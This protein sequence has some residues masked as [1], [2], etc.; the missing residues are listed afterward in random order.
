MFLTPTHFWLRCPLAIDNDRSP[1]LIEMETHTFA[2]LS[3]TVSF[4][5]PGSDCDYNWQSPLGCK[6]DTVINKAPST[7]W[8]VSVITK[9]HF[10][11]SPKLSKHA[12]FLLSQITFFRTPFQNSSCPQKSV[13]RSAFHVLLLNLERLFTNPEENVHRK[14]IRRGTRTALLY[15]THDI[16]LADASQCLFEGNWFQRISFFLFLTVSAVW[17]VRLSAQ[18]DAC[19]SC[20]DE[21]ISWFVMKCHDISWQTT[22]F[23]MKF[24]QIL[25]YVMKC[26]Q[27][28]W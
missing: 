18:I 28:S 12:L 22:C 20:S 9:L 5:D 11:P 6:Y 15:Q 3:W 8:T 21:V 16:P 25:S 1:R 23:V 14:F 17:I 7:N 4:C 13:G 19:L 2:P 26:H 10:F 24:H 27:I